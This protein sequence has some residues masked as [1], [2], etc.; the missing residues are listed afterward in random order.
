[1]GKLGRWKRVLNSRSAPVQSQL[2]CSGIASFDIDQGYAGDLQ[3]FR[4]SY[5]DIGPHMGSVGIPYIPNNITPPKDAVRDFDEKRVSGLL[6]TLEETMES[7]AD[8]KTPQPS[9][10]IPRKGSLLAAGDADSVQVT[11]LATEEESVADIPP[12]SR[13][14]INDETPEIAGQRLDVTNPDE[15]TIDVASS[16]TSPTHLSA[17]PV[18]RDPSRDADEK[19]S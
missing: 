12:D 2:D 8:T 4:Q 7:D 18:V 10:L 5:G 19:V 9:I 3:K 11:P 6:S 13:P 1:M 15:P 16:E 14:S 17:P